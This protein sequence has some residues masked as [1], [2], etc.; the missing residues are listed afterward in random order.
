MATLAPYPPQPLASSS[1]SPS[2]GPEH[3]TYSKVEI[4]YPDSTRDHDMVPL[5]GHGS[6]RSPSPTPSE[7][8]ELK[9]FEG[10]L[11]KLFRKESWKNKAFLCKHLS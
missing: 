1:R 6:R 10:T 9:E 8:L 5:T 7:K 2:P 3:I 11:A 4:D